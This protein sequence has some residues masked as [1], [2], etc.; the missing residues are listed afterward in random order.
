[1]PRY[2]LEKGSAVLIKEDKLPRL[3]WSFGVV[4][5]LFPGKDGVI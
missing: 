3:R 1:M 4:V 2:N 5:E